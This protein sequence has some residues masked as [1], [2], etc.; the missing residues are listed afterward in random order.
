MLQRVVFDSNTTLTSLN[1]DA[2][3][4]NLADDFD[5]TTFSHD[6]ILNDSVTSLT[7]NE[8]NLYNPAAL[9]E[10]FVDDNPVNLVNGGF[11]LRI[12]SY[13]VCYTK[14]LRW[15]ILTRSCNCK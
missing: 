14:L 8:F 2:G 10:I 5:L 3:A 12:T 4:A 6:I 1:I 7:F 9:I 13:N 15:F 11:V